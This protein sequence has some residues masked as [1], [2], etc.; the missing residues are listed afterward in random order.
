MKMLKNSQNEAF[1]VEKTYFKAEKI[2]FLTS[3]MSGLEMRCCVGCVRLVTAA[4]LPVRGQ[5]GSKQG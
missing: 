4:S 1:S 5:A 3:P 2:P